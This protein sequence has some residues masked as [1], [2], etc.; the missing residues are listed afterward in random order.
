V[1]AVLREEGRIDALVLN[2]GMSEPASLVD[3]TPESTSTA[4]SAP[5]SAGQSWGSR[6]RCLRGGRLR[7]SDRLDSRIGWSCQLRNL[8]R[9]E[10]G[11]ALLCQKLD[12]RTG[13][14]RH[15]RERRQP[16]PDR[17]RHVRSGPEDARAAITSQ[18]PLGR[19]ARVDEV[20]AAAAFPLS[21]EASFIA[22][23]ELCVDGGANQV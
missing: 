1:A 9:H 5:T 16:R 4:T 11:I 13:A 23:A 10:D 21:D 6:L 19:M 8:C 15:S 18:I 20:A 14:A 2:A 22:G 12:G 17:Y 3:E 7:R